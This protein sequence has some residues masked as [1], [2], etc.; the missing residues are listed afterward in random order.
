[1]TLG[2]G[3]ATIHKVNP[4]TTKSNKSSKT[5]TTSTTSLTSLKLGL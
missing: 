3:N 4:S 1:M 2:R 5:S